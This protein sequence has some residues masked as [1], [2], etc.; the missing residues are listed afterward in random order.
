MIH[1]LGV[2]AFCEGAGAALARDGEVAAAIHEET[3]S[4]RRGDANF[5]KRSIEACLRIANISADALDGV[6]F[7]EKPF[8]KFERILQSQLYSFPRSRRNFSR[9]LFVWLG[10]RLWIKGR[11]AHEIGVAP[12]KIFFVRRGVAEATAAF[13][14]SPFDSAAILM[15]DKVAEWDTTL[16]MRGQGSAVETLRSVTFPNSLGF[17][18]AA[19]AKYLGFEGEGGEEAVAALAAYGGSRYYEQLKSYI[20]IRADGGFELKFTKRELHRDAE[21]GICKELSIAFGEARRPGAP[22]RIVGNDRREADFAASWQRLLTDAILSLARNLARETGDENLVFCGTVANNRTL[23]SAVLKEENFRNIY[24]PPAAGARSAAVGAA[25]FG[26]HRIF[27]I[28]RVAPSAPGGS[29][30]EL[31]ESPDGKLIKDDGEIVKITVR[32]LIQG[33]VVGWARGRVDWGARSLTNRCILADPRD[34]NMKDKVNQKLKRREAFLP[35]ACAVLEERAGELLQFNPGAVP[36]AREKMMVLDAAPGAKVQ[37]PAALHINNTALALF[38]TKNS[39]PLLN[40]VLEG[41]AD[42]T[43][44]PALLHASLRLRGDPIAATQ[45]DA[46]SIFERSALDALIIENRLY[47][48][49]AAEN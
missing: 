29:F 42:A 39:D 49:V 18:S 36:A 19:V 45:A 40:K 21:E 48:R 25:L 27:H 5:P 23:G 13:L 41:F 8:L 46:L 20:D 15:I 9:E 34:C 10:D 26:S 32:M 28:P 43:G 1:V 22:V 38:I 17:F 7:S 24:I 2:T 16:L 6:V 37:I 12:E 3:L 47:E 30:L 14:T 4:G 35:Y 33:K 31:S 11:I 44:V